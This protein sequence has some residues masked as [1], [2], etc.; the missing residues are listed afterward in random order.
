MKWNLNQEWFRKILALNCIKTIPKFPTCSWRT[1]ALSISNTSI[2]SLCGNWYLFTPTITSSPESMRAEVHQHTRHQVQAT[3][4]AT[5][6]NHCFFLSHYPLLTSLRS[7]CSSHSFVCSPCFFAEFSS[8][9][10]LGQPA[11]I[12]LV[13]PPFASISSITSRAAS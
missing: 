10:R 9:A 11:M 13:I 4:T 5:R 7:L 1:A 8:M 6:N 3:T 12:A 2:C